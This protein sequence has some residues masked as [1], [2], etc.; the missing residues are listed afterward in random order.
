MHETKRLRVEVKDA[1][2]GIVEAVFS[3]FDV[4]DLDG[5]V[6]RK[7]AF[8][9][10]APVRIS[11]YNHASWSGALPVGKGVLRV[12]D[13]VAVMQGEFFLQ[14]T[15]GR[16][17]F[18]VIKQ[19][20]DLQQWSYGFDVT[21][22]SFGEF[23]GQKDVRFLEGLQVHEVSPVLLGAGIDTMT[24]A[25]KNAARGLSFTQEAETVLAVV[26]AF[27]DRSKALAAIRAKD[28]RV[29]SAANRERLGALAGQLREGLAEL[30]TLLA[31]TERDDPNEPK[32][33][34]PDGLRAWLSSERTRLLLQ[35]RS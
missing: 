15:Q 13:D 7:D 2:Q 34:S 16:D 29:L 17:T 35:P 32:L 27:T 14:T 23:D 10:G 21:K 8:T 18:E 30:D 33:L 3:R 31:E 5:D 26:E 11:A 25:V 19:M 12:R 6:T 9:D 20:G 22:H 24:L 28:G 4:V 1:D